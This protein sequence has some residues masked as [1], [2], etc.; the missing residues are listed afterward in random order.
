M[1]ENEVVQELA[2]KVKIPKGIKEA[3]FDKLF[4]NLCLAIV[5]VLYLIFTNIGY[6]K[7]NGEVFESDLHMFA[8]I[9]IVLTVYAFEMAYRKSSI[10]I[11][12]YAIE[13]LVLSVITL[14]MPYVYFY[15]GTLLKFLYGFT[16]VYITVY[17]LIKCIV[18]YISEVNKYKSGLSDIKE[19]IEDEEETYLDEENKKKFNYADEEDVRVAKDDNK[20]KKSDDLE[21]NNKT[22]KKKGKKKTK[23]KKNEKS[24]KEEKQ[25]KETKIEEKNDDE[26]DLEIKEKK[27]KKQS[28]A[29]KKTTR[30]KKGE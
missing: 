21:N 11:G 22:E 10:E 7:L 19:I 3:I 23:A 14:F 25:D 20:F 2:T 9:L 4:K 5:V 8:G 1:E 24:K 30:K 27:S 15:R 16:S 29:K 26:I 17:Y 6:V 13:L 12:M 28:T 18:I